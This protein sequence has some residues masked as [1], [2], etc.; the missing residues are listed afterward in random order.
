MAE[1]YKRYRPVYPQALYEMFMEYLKKTVCLKK[2]NLIISFVMFLCMVS[3]LPGPYTLAV[4][5]GCGSGQSAFGM[6]SYFD[7]ILGVEISEEQIRE[8]CADPSKP[9]NVKL[10]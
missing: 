10:V 2:Y 9:A 4:D 6:A 8:G 3:Q 1:R 7:R 5:V